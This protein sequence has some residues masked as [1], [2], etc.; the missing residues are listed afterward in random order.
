MTRGLYTGL[1]CGLFFCCAVL[2]FGAFA[3][4]LIADLS[5]HTIEIHSGFNG[6]ELLLYGARFEA[7]DLVVVVRGPYKKVTVRKKERVAGLWVNRSHISYPMVPEYYLQ[8]STRPLAMITSPE[9]LQMLDIGVDRQFNNPRL[10]SKKMQKNE[11]VF[12]AALQDAWFAKRLYADELEDIGFIGDS[13]FRTVVRFPETIPRGMYTAETYLFRYG[14]LI[15]MHTT[16]LPVVKSGMDAKIYDLA[17]QHPSLYGLLAIFLAML[18]GWLTNV[19][20]NKR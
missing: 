15:G 13:L 11:P 8:A 19:F 10:K 1:A 5:G 6:T 9:I 2:S 18:A 7:G 20:F 4:P 12:R 3:R 16:P 14:E 17:H